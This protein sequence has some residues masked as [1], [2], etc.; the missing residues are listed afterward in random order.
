MQGIDS[1]RVRLAE[2]WAMMRCICDYPPLH[3]IWQVSCHTSCRSGSN[4]AED[5]PDVGGLLRHSGQNGLDQ[6][7]VDVGKPHVAA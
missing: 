4:D 7:A 1:S 5:I 3:G 2:F 6:F